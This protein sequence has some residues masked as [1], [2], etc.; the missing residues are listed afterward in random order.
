MAFKTPVM[1]LHIIAN[2]LKGIAYEDLTPAEENIVL[3]LERYG[4]LTGYLTP[5]EEAEG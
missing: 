1:I 3:L 4:Y 2:Y 5:D